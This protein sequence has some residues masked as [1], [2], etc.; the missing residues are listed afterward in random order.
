[1]T[2]E[3]SIIGSWIATDNTGQAGGIVSFVFLSD[4]KF[5]MAQNGSSIADPSGSPG[6]E[7][8]TYTWDKASGAF[9]DVIL[10]DTNGEWGTSHSYNT[11]MS[12][13]GDVLTIANSNPDESPT[14]LTRVDTAGSFVD[15]G[16]KISAA[17][18]YAILDLE[19]SKVEDTLQFTLNATPDDDSYDGVIAYETFNGH[20]NK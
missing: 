16:I 7:Y 14:T 19:V 13:I 9:V 2:T 1:M 5:I 10:A 12:V 11:N 3:S 6:L 4:G 15:S 18:L 17:N 20:G 8:G